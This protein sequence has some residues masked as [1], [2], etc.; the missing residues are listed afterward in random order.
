MKASPIPKRLMP[1]LLCLALSLC[2]T[3]AFAQESG[4]DRADPLS[5]ALMP[6]PALS[7]GDVIR[8]QLE[9]LRHNDE[10]DR[11]IAVAFRF[12]SPANRANTGPLSR[13]TA[14]I[15]EG[16]YAL[17][18][19]F[20]DATYD[21]VET[22]SGRARQRV[23]LTGTRERMTYWFYLSRQSEAPCEGCWMTDAVFVEQP[24]DQFRLTG[25]APSGM[26]FSSH[27]QI[28]RASPE[29]DVFSVPT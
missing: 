12:A 28:C 23:T 16:P 1:A 21:P 24:T 15:K 17:M 27:Y 5:E 8:I 11:G 14:M 4:P 25:R 3:P 10:Q 13:F 2:A 6:E 19:D 9:A 7:P 18:L 22:I 20:R 26:T 29:E